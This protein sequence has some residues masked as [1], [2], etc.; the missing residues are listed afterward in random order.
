MTFSGDEFSK[1][2]LTSL[3]FSEF[4]VDCLVNGKKWEIPGDEASVRTAALRLFDLK[5]FNQNDE[6]KLQKINLL[7]DRFV[8]TVS[9]EC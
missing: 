3:H 7:S 4:E 1:S 6:E 2:K 8:K 5:R 9:G